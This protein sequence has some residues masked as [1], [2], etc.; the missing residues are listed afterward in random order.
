MPV[1]RPL[2]MTDESDL[3]LR[4]EQKVYTL[5]DNLMIIPRWA[6]DVTV[7][8][9][10]W[11]IIPFEDTDDNYQAFV[12]LR[13][14]SI[15]PLANLVQSTEDYSVDSLTVLV[16]TDANGEA[17]G[18]LYEDAGE[19]FAY[20]YGDYAVSSIK[21]TT[22]GKYLTVSIEKTEG[23]RESSV[24]NLRVG[25]V[26]DGKVTYSAWTEGTTVTMK[27][28]KEKEFSIDPSKLK[29]S[30]IDVDAQPTYMQKLQIQMEK[31]RKA[32]QAFEW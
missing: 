22:E 15:V 24:K 2:W 13:P 1:M 30:D 11:D 31:M 7:A 23:D 8:K 6:K 16:N 3:S 25:I 26:T 27:T 21:A 5:G 9:G 20:R 4:T 12:A 18:S 32:G 29:W 14:G 10:D 17:V 28:V 19:G